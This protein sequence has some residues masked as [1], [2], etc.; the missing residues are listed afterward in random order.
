MLTRFGNAGKE[1]ELVK[2]DI[3]AQHIDV[4]V[5]A[6]NPGLMGGGGVDGAIH[7]AGGPSILEECRKIRERQGG[8]APGQAVITTAGKLSAKKVIHTVGPVWRG[9][10]AGEP[11][12]LERCY[13]SCLHLAAEHGL[14]TI[15]FPSIGTGAYGYPIEEAAPIAILTVYREM[16]GLDID[17]IRFVLFTQKDLVVYSNVLYGVMQGIVV[18]GVKRF[19]RDVH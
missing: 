9:G 17:E 13:V 6:A 7:A 10:T 18:T 1:I 19:R 14:R 12:T 2:G 3:T 16:K 8:C 5:N 15:A 4:I 11:E